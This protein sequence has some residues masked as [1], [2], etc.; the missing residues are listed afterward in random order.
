MTTIALPTRPTFP[1]RVKAAAALALPLG[2]MNCIGVIVFWDWSWTTPVGVFGAFM[3]VLTLTGA[4]KTLRGRADGPRILRTAM[5]C[6]IGFTVLKLVGWQETAA[7]GFGLV[8]LAIAAA[9]RER[10]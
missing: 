1:A 10:G 2:V 5:Y 8:A 9:L 4:V 7:I 3:G 6:Q